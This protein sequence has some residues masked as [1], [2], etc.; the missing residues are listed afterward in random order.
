MSHVLGAE[1]LD[2]LRPGGGL[3]AERRLAADAGELVDYF[4]RKAVGVGREGRLRDDARHLPVARDRVLALAAFAQAGHAGAGLG[5]GRDSGYLCEA[6]QAQGGEVREMQPPQAAGDVAY[7]VRA[8]SI[9]IGGCVVQGADA[10]GVDYEYNKT[11]HQ[12]VSPSKGR[13]G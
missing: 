6:P 8:G 5:D 13:G 9:S 2:D 10:A 12:D 7:R 3:I 4:L 1:L 11:G